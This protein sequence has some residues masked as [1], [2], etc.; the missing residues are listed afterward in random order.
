MRKWLMSS[1]S[2]LSLALLAA[3]TTTQVVSSGLAL[4]EGQIDAGR[5]SFRRLQC[6]SCHRV[7]GE[8]GLPDPMQGLAVPFALG[9]KAA[10][11]PT[12][13]RLVTAIINPSH[14]ITEPFRKELVAHGGRSRMTNYSEV[15]TV[16][17]LIDLVAYIRAAHDGKLK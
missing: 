6:F 14:R 7:A 3:C 16:Q 5:E 10:S 15:M 4:P 1:A 8:T 2:G 13:E 11:R 12:D 9:R 17:E